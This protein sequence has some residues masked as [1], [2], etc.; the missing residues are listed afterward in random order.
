[1]LFHHLNVPQIPTTKQHAEWE[2]LEN[3]APYGVTLSMR[4]PQG[5]GIYD[6]ERKGRDIVRSEM[7]DSTKKTPP[8]RHNRT[9]TQ[10]L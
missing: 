8:W 7:V 10:S 6:E 9:G 3:S 1:M 4:S 2:I 5:S